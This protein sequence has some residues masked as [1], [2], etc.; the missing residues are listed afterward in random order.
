MKKS[1]IF[2]LL[3]TKHLD[4]LVSYSTKKIA[5]T[6]IHKSEH[7]T[8]YLMAFSPQQSIPVHVTQKDA[9]LMV[10]EGEAILTVGNR[11]YELNEGTTMELPGKIP[12]AVK[13]TSHFKLLIIK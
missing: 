6:V 7:T 4:E 9:F 12:H 3:A 13:A 11:L 10:L 1:D 2:P 8:V 5:T